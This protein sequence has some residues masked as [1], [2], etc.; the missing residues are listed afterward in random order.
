MDAHERRFALLLSLAHG[1]DHFSRRLLPPLIPLWA[2]AFGF[3]LWKIGLIP[4]VQ[5]LGNGLA[6]APMGVLSDR[7]D[8]RVL[9]STGIGVLGASYVVF[10][11]A[12]LV[13]ALDV[14][15]SVLGTSLGG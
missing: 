10:A 3:P 15:L 8:R 9:L 7:Y 14:E 1:L 13:G 4:A 2:V 5:L 12:P 6:Q 11:T